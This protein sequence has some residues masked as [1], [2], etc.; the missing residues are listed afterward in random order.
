MFAHRFGAILIGMALARALVAP[1]SMTT[2]PLFVEEILPS[3]T[4]KVAGGA[5]LRRLVLAARAVL[6]HWRGEGALPLRLWPNLAKRRPNLARGRPKLAEF[7][8]TLAVSARFRQI[9]PGIDRHCPM[10]ANIDPILAKFGPVSNI[11]RILTKFCPNLARSD[12]ELTKLG[13]NWPGH[14]QIWPEFDQSWPDLSATRGGGG[15][16]VIS[17]RLLSNAL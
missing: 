15:T 7:R 14:G 9:P 1:C 3:T 13:Q 6:G 4:A 11:G 10:S 17:G 5:R 16:I 2:P 12:P 8:P